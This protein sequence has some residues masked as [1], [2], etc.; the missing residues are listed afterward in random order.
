MSGE[1]AKGFGKDPLDTMLVLGMFFVLFFWLTS[2]LPINP[3]AGNSTI[4]GTAANCALN[5]P[6]SANI[7]ANCTGMAKA[8]KSI[9][10]LGILVGGPF[11]MIWIAKALASEGR[12]ID[13]DSE[14]GFSDGE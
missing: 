8:L 7:P 13:A 10:W 3:I 9:L 12:G 5:Q 1:V 6:T 14:G 2:N 11:A 4:T